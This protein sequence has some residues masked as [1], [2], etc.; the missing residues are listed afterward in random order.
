M[1]EAQG[2][3]EHNECGQE[4]EEELRH[5]NALATQ[6]GTEIKRG[7]SIE[8]EFHD[9]LSR[10]QISHPQLIDPSVKVEEVYGISR[11]LRRRSVS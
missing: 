5:E 10:V 6:V 1:I 7:G 2:L 8:E 4:K 9:Q 11:S 3:L